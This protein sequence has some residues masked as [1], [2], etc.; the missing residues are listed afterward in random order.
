MGAATFRRP[1]VASVVRMTPT[2]MI[3]PQI[4]ELKMFATVVE[5]VLCQGLL[6]RKDV[7]SV[8]YRIT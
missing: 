7:K 8:G 1:M 5:W 6:R 4:S 2:S 3:M